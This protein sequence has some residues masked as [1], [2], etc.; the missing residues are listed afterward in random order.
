METTMMLFAALCLSVVVQIQGHSWSRWYDRDDPSATG[1]WE[2]VTE[3]RKSHYICGGCKPI[4]AECRVKGSSTVFTRWRGSAPDKLAANCLPTTGLICKNADQGSGGLCKDYEIRFL[5]PSTEV[6]TGPY[7][8]R[9]DPS[10]TGDWE[11]V[12]SYR[13]TDN[14]NICL[15]VRPLCT[16][17]RDK[18]DKTPYYSTGDKFNDGLACGWDT[19]LVCTTEVNGKSCKD[20]EVQFRCPVIG[21]CTTCGN[22]RWTNWLNRDIPT[23]TGDWENVGPTGHNPCNSHEPIDIQCR[24]KSTEQPWDQTGQVFKNKCTPSEG[25]VCVNADQASGQSC[26]DYEVRFLCP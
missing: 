1:D 4:G 20:Y 15:G 22:A 9:D 25:L 8:D 18:S 21:T 10:A 7:L 11:S 23:A 12:S 17:C 16:L 3:L 5:C 26:K 14:N 19:G 2:T 24:E 6:E 13:I